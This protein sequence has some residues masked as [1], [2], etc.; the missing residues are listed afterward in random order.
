MA[1]N[2]RS[3]CYSNG[4]SI[5]HVTGDTEW[6]NAATGAVCFYNNTTSPAEREAWGA[7]YNSYAVQD[8]VFA[9][10]G[11]RV[12]D[13]TDWKILENYLIANRY[14]WDGV[15]NGI[16][17]GKSLAAKTGWITSNSQGQVGNEP[18]TN[19]ASGFSAYPA[20]ARGAGFWRQGKDAIFWISKEI[21][22]GG[23]AR[24]W[25][26]H[27]EN[28]APYSITVSFSAGNAVRLVRDVQ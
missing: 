2:Y 1:E 11:W 24:Q 14:S 16:E 19:N 20:G 18:N 23:K 12:P 3:L 28:A 9:P 26:L 13:S 8:S 15:Q 6:S 25:V 4:D 7:L 5:P 27:N 22:A 17:V 10:L 21:I